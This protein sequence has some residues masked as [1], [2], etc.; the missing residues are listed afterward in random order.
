MPFPPIPE[1]LRSLLVDP[2][3]WGKIWKGWINEIVSGPLAGATGDLLEV[4]LPRA[5]AILFALWVRSQGAIGK[6]IGESIDAVEVEAG[7]ALLEAAAAGLS[8]YFGTTVS[9]GELTLH[10]GFD[11]RRALADKLGSVIMD[12][13]LE[14]FGQGTDITPAQGLK[15]AERVIGFNLS[16]ALEG[17]MGGVLTT[18]FLSKFFPNWADLDS[19]ISQNL[20]F[21]RM[22]RRVMGPLLDELIV[23]PLREH[24]RSTYRSNLLSE[25]Q[26]VRGLFRKQI[27]EDEYFSILARRGWTR[28]DAASLKVLNGRLLE[29]EDIAKAV[30]IGAIREDELVELYETL[31]FIPELAGIMKQVTIQ[32]RIRGIN[33]ALETTARRMFRDS[34][35]EEAEYKLLLAQAER[36]PMEQDALVA[37][38]LLERSA[39]KVDPVKIRRVPR[40]TVERSFRE[41]LISLA[42]L[43]GYYEE[44]NYPPGDVALMLALQQKL[45][46]GSLQPPPEEESE[47]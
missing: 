42:Q 6:A 19:L 36:S 9:P 10:A 34:Q 33:N 41:R 4:V 25:T 22:N 21:G 37:L 1:N 5:G 15:N 18:G 32:D 38:G 44:Q 39:Q 2:P 12:S 11:N 16:T 28:E 29:K 43:Q 40:G 7:P 3:D 31:G 30:E 46:L 17:W 8:D 14:A 45:L 35:I 23:F 27:T 13:M 24:L 26:A 20:G 47:A